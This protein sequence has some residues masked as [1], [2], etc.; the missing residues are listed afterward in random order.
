MTKGKKTASRSSATLI[1][2]P[3]LSAVETKEEELA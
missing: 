3:S 2:S 1:S